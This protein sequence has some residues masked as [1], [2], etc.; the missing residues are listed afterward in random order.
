MLSAMSFAIWFFFH[1]PAIFSATKKHSADDTHVETEYNVIAFQSSRL[2]WD[3]FLWNWMKNKDLHFRHA[4]CWWKRV[5]KN[6]HPRLRHTSV[7]QVAA[8]S[9]QNSIYIFRSIESYLQ[10]ICAVFIFIFVSLVLHAAQLLSASYPRRKYHIDWLLLLHQT[11]KQ[12]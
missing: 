2:R 9:K 3:S 10:M 5:G 6:T 8:K 7:Y 11:Q 12:P 4:H 1:P